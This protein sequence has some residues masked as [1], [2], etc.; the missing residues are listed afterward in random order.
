MFLTNVRPAFVFPW[1]AAAFLLELPLRPF[2]PSLFLIVES[3]TLTLTEASEACSAL[4]GFQFFSDLCI[5]N[6]L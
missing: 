5:V 1:S 6:A 2:L 4:Y 3:Y